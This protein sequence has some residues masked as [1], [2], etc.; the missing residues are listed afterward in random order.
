[1]LFTTFPSGTTLLP[2]HTARV[3]QSR[4]ALFGLH[5]AWDLEVILQ[6]HRTETGQPFLESLPLDQT[7]RIRFDY[8]ATNWRITASA[9]QI[10]PITAL[11]IMQVPDFDYSH[12]YS[13]RSH[14]DQLKAGL[15]KHADVLI[16]TDGIVR[17]TSYCNVVFAEGVKAKKYYTPAL[18]LLTGTQRAAVIDAG[19]IEPIEIK[20]SDLKRFR[21]VFCINAMIPLGAVRVDMRSVRSL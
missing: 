2:Y 11:R 20:I 16:C 5:D 3:R 18:P 14:L 13:D 10:K 6:N 4:A 19:E 17:D 12:K 15:P 21:H 1:M 8:D 9:Y 7:T